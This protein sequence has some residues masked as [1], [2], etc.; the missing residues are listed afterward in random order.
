MENWTPKQ[1]S[2]EETLLVKYLIDRVTSRASGHLDNEC[3][4]DMPR[5]KYFIGNL[6]SSQG[7]TDGQD[8]AFQRELLSK[9]APV[10]F[11]AD[12]LLASNADQIWLKITISW[13]CYYRVFPTFDE[14][15]KLLQ[16]EIEKAQVGET[17]VQDTTALPNETKE[18]NDRQSGALENEEIKAREERRGRQQNRQKDALCPKFRKISCQAEAEVTLNRVGEQWQIDK[19]ALAQS[20]AAEMERARQVVLNDPEVIKVA[21]DVDKQVKI[22]D[23][24]L[25]SMEDFQAALRN[26][27]AAVIPEWAW[28][29]DEIKVES[30]PQGDILSIIFENVSPMPNQSS[31]RESYL[32]DVTATFEFDQNVVRPFELELAPRGF[33]YD[34]LLWARGFNCA[35]TKDGDTRYHTTHTPLYIQA[36][37]DTRTQPEA[38]FDALAQDPI[39]VLQ[40]ILEA[41]RAY[42]TEWDSA[43]TDYQARYGSEWAKFQPEF[44]GDRAQF[45]AEID[46]FAQGLQLIETD[47]DV[48]LA[49]KLTNKTFRRTGDHPTK[50]KKDKWRLFQIVF[51]VAQIPDIAALKTSTPAGM[52]ER[53]MVDIIYFPTG[54][55]K[56]E[57]YLGVL[58]FHCFFDRLR[59]KTAG[60]TAWL[61]F[62][63]RLLTLQQTQRTADV[64]GMAE[65]VR[66]EQ[67][68]PRLNGKVAGFGVGYFV[69]ASSSPNILRPNSKRAEDQ[70]VWSKSNDPREREKWKRVVTCPACRTP[71]VRV[72][73]DAQKVR[74][75]HRCTNAD[76]AF[77]D[78]KIPIYIVDNEIYRYLPS[79]IVGT[80]DKLAGLGNQRK[81]S[82]I[83]GAVT[84]ICSRHGYFNGKCC[85]DECKDEKLWQKGRVPNGLTGPT[86]FVQDELHL[87][88][89]GL[90]TFD[91]HYETFTQELLK[92]MGQEG[93]LKIIASSATIEAFERQVEHLYGRQRSQARV[94]PGVGPSLAQSFYAQTRDYAQRL[95][96]GIIPHNKTI[97]NAILELLEYYHAEIQTLYNLPASAANPYGGWLQPGSDDWKELID[98]YLTSLTYFL[99][100]RHLSSI[101]TDVES[102]VNSNLASEGYNAL[103]L[104]ELTGSTL[105]GDVAHILEKVERPYQSD[106]PD[107]ILAT[108]MVSHGVDVDRFNAMIF[109]GMPRQNAEYIQASSRVGRSHVGLVLMCLH[110]VRERDQSHYNYFVKFHQFLGQLVEPVAINRWSKFSIKRTLPGLFMGVLLQLLANNSGDASPGRYYRA[111]YVKKKISTGEINKDQFIPVLKQA[112]GVLNPQTP[113]EKFFDNEIELR[114]QQLLDFII[115]ASPQ[116]EWLSDALIPRP[117]RSLRDVDEAIDIELDDTGSRWA[118]K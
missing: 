37:Y 104:A 62:P 16:F 95:F 69:G 99:A 113:A 31:N 61:R 5:D 106:S 9:I 90:G 88:R 46:R 56:T 14:Q 13:T 48:R 84:G 110:P 97:F 114:V 45:E 83:F 24:A 55:G 4:F 19:A 102:H 108:S 38:R 42:L 32:F 34:R 58:V 81:F 21:G 26:F 54:G 82:L 86:L 109:Y 20:C 36:R 100:T 105:T 30:G 18:G 35:V 44:Q 29:V 115:S 92:E 59:G 66:R 52:T 3:L 116:V 93:P 77:P 22:S 11:G 7:T 39:P 57:A 15:R 94:F 28:S 76:C 60:V 43:E 6:R 2:E 118:S 65:L 68:D 63:L 1:R 75:I 8:T 87:L 51:L 64:I 71:T 80:I 85:Q 67:S 70:V 78:G 91:S 10:A 53:E 111:D 107:A 98:L 101:R 89:E 74:L 47:P 79:V 49:F 40:E 117:M 50:P 23:E 27:S 112:Y 41:M 25:N 12:F 72:D 33:R 73:L 103:N 96:L 17:P